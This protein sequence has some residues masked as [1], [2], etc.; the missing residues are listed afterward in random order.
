MQFE[1]INW[2]QKGLVL[3]YLQFKYIF[4]AI[5]VS[6]TDVAMS[7]IKMDAKNVITYRAFSFYVMAAMLLYQDKIILN[8]FFL[9]VYTNMAANFFVV[10]IPGD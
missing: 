4:T 7:T 9:N 8:I 1:L 6:R 2:F 10:L 5:Q 3:L